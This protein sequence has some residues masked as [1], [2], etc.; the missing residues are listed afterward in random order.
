MSAKTNDGKNPEKPKEI[1][2]YKEGYWDST[3]EPIDKKFSQSEKGKEFLTKLQQLYKKMYKYHPDHM[4]WMQWEELRKWAP[5]IPAFIKGMTLEKISE[6]YKPNLFMNGE[7]GYA[8]CRICGKKDNG[9]SNFEVRYNC[10]VWEFPEGYL[11]Y[12]ESHGVEPSQKFQDFISSL[13][14]DKLNTIREL[15]PEE[16]KFLSDMRLL[17]FMDGISALRYSE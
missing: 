4:I 8:H 11:H 12:I 7:M 15:T 16:V 6:Y 13:D 14:I 10:Q 3:N 2:H 5:Y 9:S 17:R 1:E